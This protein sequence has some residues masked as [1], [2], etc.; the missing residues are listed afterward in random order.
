MNQT[1]SNTDGL[2]IKREDPVADLTGLTGSA[3][4]VAAG[5]A[6]PIEQ[7][8]GGVAGSVESIVPEV[9]DSMSIQWGK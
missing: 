3:G 1:N 9:V 2:P 8:I 6:A 4:S 5:L 7:T